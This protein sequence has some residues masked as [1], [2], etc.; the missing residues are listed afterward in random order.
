M[1]Y[2]SD[3]TSE[4]ELVIFC[5]PTTDVEGNHS[6]KASLEHVRFGIKSSS[7]ET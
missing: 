6:F 5:N 3:A 4:E 7:M 2:V 1:D